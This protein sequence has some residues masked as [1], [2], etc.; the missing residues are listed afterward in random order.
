MYRYKLWVRIDSF[1]TIDVYV[2]ADY[3]LQAKLIG[4]AQYGAG[5]VLNYTLVNE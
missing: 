4:E 1:T 5:N 2:Y 3:D